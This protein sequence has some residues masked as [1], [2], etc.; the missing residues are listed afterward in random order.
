MSINYVD[1]I[2][3][4]IPNRLR[5][6]R[7]FRNLVEQIIYAMSQIAAATGETSSGGDTT[8]VNEAE[9]DVLSTVQRVQVLEER[10]RETERLLVESYDDYAIQSR[11]DDLER[12]MVDVLSGC[13]KGYIN[14]D[15]EGVTHYATDREFITASLNAT[16]LLPSRP[17]RDSVIIVKKIDKSTRIQISG[18]GK[19]IDSHGCVSIRNKNTSLTFHFNVEKDEWFIR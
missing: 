11:I 14:K 1:L 19:N 4:A 8:I 2:R 15:V 18:N 7:E 6:D 5:G 9:N 10:D 16:I 17:I 3:K 12:Q 13:D